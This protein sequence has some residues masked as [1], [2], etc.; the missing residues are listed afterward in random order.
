MHN[1]Y[2]SI[3]LVQRECKAGK[4]FLILYTLYT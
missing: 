1:D 3:V 4:L 2:I